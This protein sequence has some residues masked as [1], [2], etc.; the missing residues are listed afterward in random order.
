MVALSELAKRLIDGKNFAFLATVGKDCSPQVTPVWVD[1]EGDVIRVNT[2]VG[3]AKQRNTKR[4]PRVSLA[5]VDWENPYTRVVIMGRVVEQTTEGA[6]E[7]I[8]SLAKKY[9]GVEKYPW[10]RGEQRII[11]KIEAEKIIEKAS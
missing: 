4:D 10:R 3:R 1:R 6:D 8:D 5:L 9:L 11:L 7:H 2:A